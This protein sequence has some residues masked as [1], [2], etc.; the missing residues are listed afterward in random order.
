MMELHMNSTWWK[1]LGARKS[2]RAKNAPRPRNFHPA[3]EQLEQRCVMDVRSIT[4]VGNNLLAGQMNWGAA[5]TDLLRV[6][7]VAYANGTDSPSTPNDLNP[8][9]ISNNLNNQSSFIFS[10]MD[11][12]GGKQSKSLSDFAYVWGQFLDHDLDLTTDNSG[13]AFNIPADTRTFTQPDGTTVSDPMNAG[14]PF[15]RSNA[16]TVAGVRQQINSVTSFEDLSEVYGSTDFIASAL[17]T[18]SGGLLKTSPGNLLPFNSLAYF[19]QAEL[20]AM[21]MANDSQQ[22]PSAQLFAAGDRRANENIELTAIQTLF[23]RNHNRLANQLHGLNPASFGYTSWTDENLYQ[24]ARKLNIAESEIITYTEFVPAIIGPGVLPAYTGY[25]NNVNP[26]ISTEFSTVGFRFGHSLL[27]NAIGRHLNNGNDIN[28]TASAN[29]AAIPLVE[30]FFRPDLISAAAHTVN[31]VDVNGNPDPHTSSNIGAILK[32]DA[33]NAANENDLLLI[34]SVRNTLFGDPF[35]GLGTD[36]AARDIQRARDHGIGTYNQLR[37]AYGLPAVTSFDQITEND[38]VQ[39]QLRATYGT[40]GRIDPFEGMLAEDHVGNGDVGPLLRAMLV[41]QF[42]NLRD[43]DRFFYLNESFTT[44]EQNLIAQGNT[45]SKVIKNNTSITNLQANAFFFKES[46]QGTVFIDADRDGSAHPT[47]G[48]PGSAGVTINLLAADGVT[49]LATT[50]TDANGHYSFTDQTGIPGTGD[51][52][53]QIVVPDGFDLTSSS[54][55]I[56]HHLGRG[57]LDIDNVDFGIAMTV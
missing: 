51:F 49:V 52:F 1:S 5:G 36:L 9:V 12:L 17:R 37:V 57:G 50:T 18:H 45:L 42:K 32:G 4:G 7:P 29:G 21:N 24:E 47:A 20:D 19:S 2:K 22:V 23:M 48:E 16:H 25:K 53:V 10:G 40:V 6:S 41:K 8:R 11:D 55:M 13:I 27:S 26:G 54:I 39:A 43:G 33:D 44:A 31:L 14:E 34:D 3:V 56:P 15:G 28:D 30:G 35:P 46:I 38:A